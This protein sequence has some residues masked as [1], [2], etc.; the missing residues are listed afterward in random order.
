MILTLVALKALHIYVLSP[1]PPTSA[2]KH[3][4]QG[5]VVF[6]SHSVNDQMIP[7]LYSQDGTKILPTPTPAL[8]LSLYLYLFPD[9]T[10]AP[11]EKTTQRNPVQPSLLQTWTKS[12]PRR[13]MRARSPS[14][15]RARSGFDGSACGPTSVRFIG[16]RSELKRVEPIRNKT[17]KATCCLIGPI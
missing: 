16:R 9:T 6:G 12:L 8:S 17:A 10:L 3:F 13:P 11:E 7:F 1:R 5:W 2:W 14:Q 15:W 4:E